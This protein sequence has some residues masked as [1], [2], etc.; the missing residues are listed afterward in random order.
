MVVPFLTKHN[1]ADPYKN[2][3]ENSELVIRLIEEYCVKS[4]D[5]QSIFNKMYR[6]DGHAIIWSNWKDILISKINPSTILCTNTNFWSEMDDSIEPIVPNAN[7]S[8]P[9]WRIVEIEQE[10]FKSFISGMFSNS[11]GISH[12]KGRIPV[13]NNICLIWWEYMTNLLQHKASKTKLQDNVMGTF[14]KQS[15]ISSS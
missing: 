6:T 15:K 13:T 3:A 10:A 8:D 2:A 11:D 12:S 14:S 5:K 7:F 1:L 4:D 9:D